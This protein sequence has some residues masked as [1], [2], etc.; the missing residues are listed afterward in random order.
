MMKDLE[1][2]LWGKNSKKIDA[3]CNKINKQFNLLEFTMYELRWIT[4]LWR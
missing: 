2:N 1:F 3:T 4:G